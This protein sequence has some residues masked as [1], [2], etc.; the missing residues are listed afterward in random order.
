MFSSMLQFEYQIFGRVYSGMAKEIIN[1]VLPIKTYDTTKTDTWTKEQWQEYIGEEKDHD[2]IQLLLMNDND[3]Y[4]KITLIYFN[5]ATEEMFFNFD[6]QNKIDRNINIQFGQWQ[7]DDSIYNLSS[8]KPLY[9]D[10]FSNV[11]SFQRCVKRSY[12]EEWDKTIIEITILDAETNI[13]IRELEFQIIKHYI[14]ILQ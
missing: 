3:F 4:L 14:Q 6:T 2:G 11:R 1:V 8:Q 10:R 5:E 13:I 9:L 12:L 7:I